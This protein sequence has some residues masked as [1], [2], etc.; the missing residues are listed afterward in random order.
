MS[1]NKTFIYYLYVHI[2]T[3]VKEG[4]IKL[5]LSVNKKTTEEF[6][7]VCDSEGWKLGRQ[8]EKLM[9]EAMRKRR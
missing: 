9:S 2:R 4:N 3:L 1:V 5:T 7:R 6:K 8:I